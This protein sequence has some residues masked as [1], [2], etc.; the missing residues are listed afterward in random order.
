MP[1]PV[2]LLQA[3]VDL[4]QEVGFLWRNQHGIGVIELA[5]LAFAEVI[6]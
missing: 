6:G 1:I 5:A 2:D 4:L 3:L